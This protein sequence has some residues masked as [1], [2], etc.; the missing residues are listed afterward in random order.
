MAGNNTK[1][2]KQANTYLVLNSIISAESITI[3]DVVKK[4][5]LSRP[6]IVNIVKELTEKNIVFKSGY[7]EYTGGRLPTLL[8]LNANSYYTIGIDFEFPPIRMAISNLKGEVV[9]KRGITVERHFSRNQIIELMFQE[10]DGMIAE[11]GI[12]KEQ[13]IGIGIGM[14]GYLKANQGISVEIIRIPDWKDVD[15]KQLI[16]ERF[17]LPVYV[18]NDIHMMALAEKR[19]FL[20]D[21]E[22]DF[23]YVGIRPGIRSGIG[24]AMQINGSFYGGVNG[25]AHLLGHMT[26]DVNGEPC[27][28]GSRGC[29]E[30]IAGEPNV[31]KRYKALIGDGED[32]EHIRGIR[33]IYARSLAGEQTATDVLDEVGNYMGIGIANVVKLFGLTTVVIGGPDSELYTNL[34]RDHLKKNIFKHMSG[35]MNLIVG[36]LEQDLYP[37]GSCFLVIDQFFKE[38]TLNL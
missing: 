34:I 38:P 8:S 36:R 7:A 15:F 18:Q 19:L 33:D 29:L 14:L 9:H 27:T 20:P 1:I 37:L 5:K 32:L 30:L 4:T 35:E 12:A 10:L 6:T 16:K 11:S 24:L 31:I 28:C 25:N 23:A 3:E 21:L 17:G 13:F 22:E 2:L 26:I